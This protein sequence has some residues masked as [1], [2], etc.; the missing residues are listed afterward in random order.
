MPKTKTLKEIEKEVGEEKY[1]YIERY[2][3]I[4]DDNKSLLL[5]IPAGIRDHMK[6]KKGDKLFFKV[7]AEGRNLKIKYIKNGT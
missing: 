4:S 6:M 7:R 1:D 2:A 5:R 3:T